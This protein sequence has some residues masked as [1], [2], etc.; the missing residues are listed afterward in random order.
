MFLSCESDSRLLEET[1]YL[2]VNA[3]MD[4]ALVTKADEKDQQISVAIC[5]AA[6]DTVQFFEN[7]KTD[8]GTKKVQLATGTYHIK[9]GTVHAGK[10]TFDKPFYFGI[11]TIQV[12]KGKLKEAEVVCTQANVKV[13]VNYSDLLKKFFTGYKATISNVSG[14]LTFEEEEKRAGYFA[15]GKLNVTL[16]LVNNDG[17]AYKIVK[18]IP[19]TKAREHYRLTFSIG[20]EPDSPEAGGDFDITVD[21]ST[22]DIDCTLKVPVF[23]DDY[24]RN[25]PKITCMPGDKLSIKETNPENKFQLTSQITSKNGFQVVALKLNSQYFNVQEGLPAYIDLM[26]ADEVMYGKLSGMGISYPKLS[27]TMSDVTIDFSALLKMLPLSVDGKKTSHSIAI[28]VRDNLGQQVEDTVVV[29]VRPNVN[30]VVEAIPWA[31]FAFLKIVTGS[32]DNIVV[33][34]KQQ[35]D[36]EEKTIQ[37]DPSQVVINSDGDYEAQCVLPDL[38]RK[39]SYSYTVIADIEQPVTGIFDTDDEYSIPNLQFEQGYY[40]GKTWYPN[41]SGGNSYWATGNEGLTS[42]LAG[43]KPSNTVETTDVATLNSTKAVKMTSVGGI[44]IVG[45][46]AG[47]LFTGK[48][49][50]KISTNPEELKK[51]VQ[52]GRDYKGRPTKLTG[53]YKYKPAPITIGKAP[54]GS[55]TDKAHIYIQLMDKSGKQIGYGE[56]VEANEVTDYTEFSIDIVYIDETVQPA[57]V[58]LVATSSKFGGDFI[59]GVGSELYVDEFNLLFDYNSKSFK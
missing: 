27:E 12:E 30:V 6:G 21:E 4:Y 45:H 5:K 20:E 22:N 26:H 36:S 11:D 8:L 34:Y 19:D 33:K 2:Y 51:S 29:E 40:D 53:W 31:R 42:T 59:G 14:E 16:N 39:T 13:T 10:A 58:T 52:F 49:N 55:K 48:F 9:A 37:V 18:E 32:P 44:T 35:S 47:N 57:S 23:T 56:K 3:S 50:M 38:K 15:P 46:A 28:V 1:G 25:M 24:G 41:E 7:Y 54:D 17:T 43:S